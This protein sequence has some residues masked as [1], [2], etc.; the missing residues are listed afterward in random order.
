LTTYRAAARVSSATASIG[1]ACEATAA[2]GGYGPSDTTFGNIANELSG[3]WPLWPISID[4]S[5][6]G[7]RGRL[8]TLVDIW[9]GSSAVAS[10]DSYP[11]TGTTGQF[12]QF[13][14]LVIPWNGGAVNLS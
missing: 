2:S 7:A 11:A 8:G 6:V 1:M 4:C 10:G 9:M 14:N 3:E 12:A 13:N 5:T